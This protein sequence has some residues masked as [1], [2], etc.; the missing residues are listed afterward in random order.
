M[1][2]VEEYIKL[3]QKE[4]RTR[5][6]THKYRTNTYHTYGHYQV[7]SSII[8]I[9]TEQNQIIMP[10]YHPS[11]EINASN[12]TSVAGDGP[13]PSARK[14]KPKNRR[15][16]KSKSMFKSKSRHNSKDY[17]VNEDCSTVYRNSYCPVTDISYEGRVL[18]VSPSKCTTTD[19]HTHPPTSRTALATTGTSGR[20]QYI[21]HGKGVVHD[22]ANAFSIQGFFQND[23]IVGHALQ[24]LYQSCLTSA[25]P[26]GGDAGLA[27]TGIILAQYEGTFLQTTT[28][29]ELLVE[30]EGKMAGAV[31]GAS[32][33]KCTWQRHG[34]GKYTWHLTENTYSGSFRHDLPEGQGVFV[35]GRTGDR[36]EGP[37]KK[38]RMHGEGGTKVIHNFGKDDGNV[39][40]DLFEGRFKRDKAHGWGRMKFGNGDLFDGMYYKD[41]R[42]G[43]GTYTWNNGDT[44]IGNW[45]AG[46]TVGRGARTL[47]HSHSR[48]NTCTDFDAAIIGNDIHN[49]HLYRRRTSTRMDA[50]EEEEELELLSPGDTSQVY[51]GEFV[52]NNTASASSSTPTSLTV[53][54]IKM[55]ACGDTYYGSFIQLPTNE[56]L[57]IP[58]GYG[59]YTWSNGDQYEGEF[60]EGRM[61]GQG[62][63]KMRNGDVY[64]GEWVDGRADGYGVKTFGNEHG[65]ANANGCVAHMGF[66][67]KDERHGRG[68]MVWV[69]GDEYDGDFVDGNPCGFGVYTYSNLN[70]DTNA[71]HGVG[72]G[73]E[74]CTLHRGQW[75][76]GR[77]HGPIYSKVV[78]RG[79]CRIYREVWC[80]GK[81]ICSQR[82]VLD[83]DNDLL[84]TVHSDNSDVW[85]DCLPSIELLR[86]QGFYLDEIVRSS[87]DA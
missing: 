37:F 24:T 45:E 76:K 84:G 81:C 52:S 17:V 83:G 34:T 42:Q 22:H 51:V 62:M 49:R 21:K 12:G 78:R 55:Y 73:V 64:D 74:D 4:T 10:P 60:W 18:D 72:N 16:N 2:R 1:R 69:N 58:H 79:V 39:E 27:D 3:N 19:I 59:V 44:Y 31:A 85:D 68:L 87:V 13:G 6:Y 11:S 80:K 46:K 56:L 38:G 71:I 47:V 29:K 54:G 65:G 8:N 41:L 35:W 23:R 75:F 48:N 82:I 66:Y 33:A 28:R 70:G 77:K 40:V 20:L 86:Q 53:K 26:S 5:K 15:N 57:Q 50:N 9:N 36:Y 25:R 7:V 67:R 61:N 30:A 32:I 14:K 43:F 63:K